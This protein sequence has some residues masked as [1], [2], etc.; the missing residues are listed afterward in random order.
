MAYQ[1][2]TLTLHF[3]EDKEAFSLTLGD[4]ARF[5]EQAKAGGATDEDV[6]FPETERDIDICGFSVMID[7]GA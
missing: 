5:V 7:P 3:S 4:L 2:K 1:S 6:I